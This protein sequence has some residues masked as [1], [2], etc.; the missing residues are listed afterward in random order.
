MAV[1][2]NT[3]LIEGP[4]EELADELAQFIDEQKKEGD[5]KIQP[6]VQKLL[7][8]GKK[9]DALKKLVSQ[10]VVLNSAP[11][12]TIIPAY[13][14]LLHIVRQAPNPTMFYSKIC[15]NLSQPM[16]GQQ[17]GS[18]LALTV[19]ET[20]FNIIPADD[21]ARFHVFMA[22]LSV[23]KNTNNYDALRPQLDSLKEWLAA[24]DIDEED[25]RKLYLTIADIAKESG[26][27]EDSYQNIIKAL[28]T[29]SADDS[30]SKEARDLALS[31]L[32]TSLQS[33]THFDFHDLTTLDAVQALRKS[34][35]IYF[36]L[37]ELFTTDTYEDLADFQDEHDGWLDAEKFD[38]ELLT[39][40]IR[41]L[42]LA[43]IAAS[44]GQK[45]E[46]PYSQIAKAL[47]IK[48]ED[49]EMWVIDVIRSGLVEGKLS[50][51]DKTFLIHRSTY[52]IFGENQWREIAA[53]LDMWRNSL[54]SVLKNVRAEREAFRVQKEQE[55]KEADTK[56]RDRE[57]RRDGGRGGFRGRNMPIREQQKP[58]DLPPIDPEAD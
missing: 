34:D 16:P 18:G 20:M 1:S 13:N 23:I 30:S 35:A 40:K 52:R 8:D 32:K 21:D 46:L 36:E 2:T 14:L 17:H 51:L 47:M 6:A 7:E 56:E 26:E 48:E 11:E 49:V 45:R 41:L 37:L 4:F 33:P 24:W 5:E 29:F 3:L 22:I 53:R 55:K 58:V 31:A 25:Q 50:Q 43:S 28:R 9:E 27:D 57:G 54:S 44:T 42:T 39:R 19:L 15:G 12:K 10:A 38:K